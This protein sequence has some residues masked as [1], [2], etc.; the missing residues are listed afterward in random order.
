MPAMYSGPTDWALV[1][2][3]P[4]PY[5]GTYPISE[6]GPHF[7]LSIFKYKGKLYVQSPQSSPEQ[8]HEIKDGRFSWDR[9][10][11]IITF[12]R[13]ADGKVTG[14]TLLQ[15]GEITKAKREP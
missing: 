7:A 11:A 14:F 12:N 13:D 6:N 3:E 15:N 10:K 9:I 2:K 5:S 4:S 1:R 8:L